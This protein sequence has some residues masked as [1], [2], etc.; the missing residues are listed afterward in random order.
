[1]DLLTSFGSLS[2]TAMLAF[3]AL[4]SHSATCI[5]AFAGPCL[6]SSACVVLKASG[7]FGVVE[8]TWSGVALRRWR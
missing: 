5:L 2:G 3:Y 1:M 8:V 6:A 7:P 4:E